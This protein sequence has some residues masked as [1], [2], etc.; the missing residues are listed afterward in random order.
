MKLIL[1]QMMKRKMFLEELLSE[2]SVRQS[3][4]PKGNL[5][6]RNDRGNPRYYHIVELGDSQGKYI[7]KKNHELAYQLAQKDYLQKLYQEAK[8]ELQDINAFLKKH[9]QM[10]LEDIYDNLNTYRKELVTPIV[11]SDELFVKQWESKTY[12]TNPYHV[13]EKVYQT[14][15]DE[16]VRSKSEVML[17]DMYYE[18]GI[19][20]RYEAGLQLK[21]GKRK[22]PDFTLLKVKTR[23]IIY[24]EHLGLL[25]NEEYL[26]AN[27]NKLDEYRNNGIYLGKNLL[28]TYEAEGSYLNIKEIKKMMREI[29]YGPNTKNG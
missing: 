2:I 28:I 24:H 19:P 18:L 21:N 7:S 8:E 3:M 5:R 25:D 26:H 6:I 13:E 27:L 17:A 16:L 12:E 15:K 11:L 29:F 1:D 4:L 9:E 23:E 20:Y 22:Y 10:A 14:K